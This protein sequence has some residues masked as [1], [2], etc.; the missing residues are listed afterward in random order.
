MVD[1]VHFMKYKEGFHRA[2]FSMTDR[3]RYQS[4]KPQLTELFRD[5]RVVMDPKAPVEGST[6]EDLRK[7]YGDYIAA[8]FDLVRETQYWRVSIVKGPVASKTPPAGPS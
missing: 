7:V 1:V 3:F 5:V 6:Y 8:N 2:P 4:P